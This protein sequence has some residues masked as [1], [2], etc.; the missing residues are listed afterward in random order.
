[1]F[2]MKI[3]IVTKA[4]SKVAKVNI[5]LYMVIKSCIAFAYTE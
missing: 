2:D 5:P 3:L 4:Y 1:M